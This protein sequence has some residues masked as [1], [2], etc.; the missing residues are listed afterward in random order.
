MRR[1]ARQTL[2]VPL[3]TACRYVASGETLPTLENGCY[4]RRCGMMFWTVRRGSENGLRRLLK[5]ALSM[6]GID[7]RRAEAEAAPRAGVRTGSR[8][9]RALTGSFSAC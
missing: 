5:F 3:R 1:V 4:R 9:I 6:A 7:C 2:R 8:L